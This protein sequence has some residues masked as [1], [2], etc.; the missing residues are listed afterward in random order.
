MSNKNGLSGK[1][2]PGAQPPKVPV[3]SDKRTN[4][5]GNINSSIFFYK[6]WQQQHQCFCNRQNYSTSLPVK[7]NGQWHLLDKLMAMDHSQIEQV[8]SPIFA[9]IPGL[10]PDPLENFHAPH[11]SKT[12]Y[13]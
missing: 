9:I 1:S 8:F 7:L 2:G 13:P 11:A 4:F 3:F 12:K 5:L 6:A 10:S